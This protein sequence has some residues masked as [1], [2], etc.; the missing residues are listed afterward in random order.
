MK[1]Q[2]IIKAKIY[3]FMEE[4]GY[5]NLKESEIF[6]RFVNYQILYSEYP[7]IFLGN[8]GFL[9][10]AT[11]GGPDDLGIDG[12][13]IL[14]N[15]KPIES[16]D[17]F[18]YILEQDHSIQIKFIFI[19]SK[20][21][22]GAE[23]GEYAKFAF[24]IN[25]F[26]ANEKPTIPYNKK[27]AHFVD[28]KNYVLNDKFISRWK[29]SPSITI[30]YS[31]MA[32]DPATPHIKAISARL[33]DDLKNL[34]IFGDINTE[35]IGSTRLKSIC[36]DNEN[37]FSVTF[38][39]IENMGISK[40]KG[41]E[42]SCIILCS[43]DEFIKLL[44]T[45]TG[46]LR[47][48]V[49]NDNVR[50]F[51]GNTTINNEIYETIENDPEKFVLLNNGITIVCDSFTTKNRSLM[52]TNPQIVNG[53]Q[54]SSMLYNAYKAGEKINRVPIL[55]KIISTTDASVSNQIV[56]GTNRQ[57]IVYDEAFEITRQFHKNL[58]DFFR[59]RTFANL[60]YYY[61]RRAKQ[62][63][64]NSSIRQNQKASF[65]NIIQSVVSMFLYRPDM[66]HKHESKLIREFRKRIFLDTHS[67][68]PYYTAAIAL[69]RLDKYFNEHTDLKKDFNVFKF[70][71]LTIANLL[72]SPEGANINSEKEIDRHCDA[73]L[74]RLEDGYA[75]LFA[76]AIAVFD[77]LRA[78]WTGEMGKD[79]HGIKDIH[80]FVKL[81]RDHFGGKMI[82]PNEQENSRTGKVVKIGRDRYNSHYGFIGDS[83]HNI[84]FH[85][86][87]NPALD[88]DSLRGRTV[89]FQLSDSRLGDPMAINVRVISQ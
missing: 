24:G 89:A 63:A 7:E 32:E 11:T 23:M 17:D 71:I 8:S 43:G 35:P 48:L 21:G 78:K 76:T 2:P 26:M 34:N 40:V 55:V 80:D 5:E 83:P 82:S 13:A 68:L 15:G 41:V 74:A 67:L 37:S 30:Y 79:Q 59:Y 12:I 56:K 57:N 87:S 84:F 6:E 88:F 33:K 9:E 81:I 86:S 64:A 14:V 73:L 19:Q 20:S 16:V 27:I 53:C 61:E 75:E 42:D 72:V 62:F 29:D 69:L 45:E 85:Q 44:L 54:T 10:L 52:V 39:F 47:K 51:Q 4:R 3:R 58:E 66:A 1:L 49:F 46:A 25:D 38:S 18:D 65:K 70:H 60:P 31:A 50:D 28:L 36:D 77:R 22:S